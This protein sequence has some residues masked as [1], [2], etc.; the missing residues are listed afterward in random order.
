MNIPQNLGGTI[1][2]ISQPH[3]AMGSNLYSIRWDNDQ[4]SKH[5]ER[6]LFCIGRFATLDD[7]TAA[8]EPWGSVNLTLGPQG[9]FREAHLQLRYDGHMQ[10][11]HLSQYD[12]DIWVDFLDSIF[13]A[14][15]SEIVTT[16][17]APKKPRLPDPYDR[18]APNTLCVKLD[19]RLKGRLNSLAEDV[20]SPA[21]KLVRTWI[22]EKLKGY[23]RKGSVK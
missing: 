16:Q 12:R 21:D 23:R 3:A 4:V 13:K 22:E 7:F 20:Q 9:G 2:S 5:Y 19:A 11:V 18:F 17:L 1:E 10:D 15:G 14:K 8:I 6:K